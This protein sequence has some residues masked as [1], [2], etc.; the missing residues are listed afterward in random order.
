V[1]THSPSSL[2]AG[3]AGLSGL[4]HAL[5]KEWRRAFLRFVLTLVGA[6]LAWFV[7]APAYAAGLAVAARMILPSLERTQ[8]ARYAASEGRVVAYRPVWVPGENRPRDRVDTLWAASASF[9]V[10]LFVALV[11]ATPGW[12][13]RR[14][15]RGLAAGLVVL[16]LTQVLVVV[17]TN[18]FWQQSPVLS[19]AGRVLYVPETAPIRRQIVSAL[20]NFAEIMS[21]GFFALLVYFALLAW[22]ETSRVQAHARP[23]EPCPCGSGRKFKRCCARLVV[24]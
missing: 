7:I 16:T 23:N 2:A 20:Y 1:A 11:L 19:P 9:G 14:R 21:R 22:P 5:R 8:G 4:A 15:A 13:G 10:P 24:H 18:E 3:S 12:N 17:V 6:S